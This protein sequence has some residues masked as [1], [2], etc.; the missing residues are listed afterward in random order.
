[1]INSS[2]RQALV[3]ITFGVLIGLIASGLILI[4]ASPPRGNPITL[5]PSSTSKLI[6]IYISGEVVNPGV[7]ELPLGSR[8]QDAVTSAGGLLSTADSSG[9]NLAALLIDSSQIDIPSIVDSYLTGK[10]NINTAS[11]EELDTL[12][13]IGLTAARNIVEFRIENGLFIYLEDIQ[14]VAGIGPVIY[15]KIKNLISISN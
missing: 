11:I 12:P 8:V 2:T 9:I 1:M 4:T 15:E 14:K 7:Y 3:F 10:I 5:A 6:T 13:G